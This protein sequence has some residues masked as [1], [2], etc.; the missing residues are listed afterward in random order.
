M[1]PCF[2]IYKGYLDLIFFPSCSLSAFCLL[3]IFQMQFLD[4][5]GGTEEYLGPRTLAGFL[6]ARPECSA[7]LTFFIAYSVIPC[8]KIFTNPIN[9][10]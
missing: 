8:K 3:P 6:H 1:C 2:V 9:H 7:K 5:M 10:S 4:F